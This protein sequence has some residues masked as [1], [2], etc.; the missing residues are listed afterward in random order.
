MNHVLER[1]DARNTPQF[2]LFGD[3]PTESEKYPEFPGSKAPGTSSEAARKIAG[4]ASKLRD[5]TLKEYQAAFPK[6]LTPDE[7]AK[8]L[9]ESLLSV[10]PR[11]TELKVLGLIELTPERRRNDS[12]LSAGV[13]RCT[14]KAFEVQS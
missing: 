2:E 8:L 4:H 1:A 12:G 5:D 3:F 10:R 11:C 6:G 7:A 14:S 9:G 13:L